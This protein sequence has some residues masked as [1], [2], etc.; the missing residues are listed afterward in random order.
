[1]RPRSVQ[2]TSLVLTLVLLAGCAPGPVKPA[3]ASPQER[4]D[5]LVAEADLA[6]E[7]GEAERAF[8]LY[9]EAIRTTG[10]TAS[11]AVRA[12][13]ERAKNLVLSRRI[14]TS[15]SRSF[16]NIA[17]FVQVLQYSAGATETAEAGT[18]IADQLNG[19]VREA[20]SELKA[21]KKGIAAGDS[22]EMPLA[23]QVLGGMSDEVGAELAQAPGDPGTHFSAAMAHVADAW[24]AVD[25][26]WGVRYIEEALP[27][28]ATADKKLAEAE[29]EIAAG[30]K[31]CAELVPAAE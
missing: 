10:A 3:K 27:L 12:R 16:G 8:E 21:A 4:F 6:W 19:M 15:T 18:A 30:E 13:Q 7:D 1:M 14:L 24:E 2:F 9:N 28:L 17:P 31:A 5:A 29:R 23:V 25:K 22:V 26:A 20:R 11:D